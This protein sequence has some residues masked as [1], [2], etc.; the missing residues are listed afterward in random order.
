VFEECSAFVWNFVLEGKSEFSLL[1]LFFF[2]CEATKQRSL[3]VNAG[4]DF[5]SNPLISLF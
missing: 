2:L 5:L 4:C 1:I 3:I